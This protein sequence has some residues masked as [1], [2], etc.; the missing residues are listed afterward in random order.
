MNWE[1]NPWRI[2]P[3]QQSWFNPRELYVVGWDPDFG[4]FTSYIAKGEDDEVG[5]IVK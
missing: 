3:Y 4:G 1:E 5:F 2:V